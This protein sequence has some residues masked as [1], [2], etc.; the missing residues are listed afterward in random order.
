MGPKNFVLF[1]LQPKIPPKLK[2]G[3]PRHLLGSPSG[4]TLGRLLHGSPSPAHLSEPPPSRHSPLL[5]EA[6]ANVAQNLTL[7]V[8]PNKMAC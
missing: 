8:S 7:S 6:Q 3:P 2:P 5:D 4:R 1:P